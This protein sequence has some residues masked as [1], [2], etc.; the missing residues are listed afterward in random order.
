MT[1]CMVLTLV[2]CRIEYI[3]LTARNLG[4]RNSKAV[5]YAFKD[6]DVVCK[7]RVQIARE[8]DCA[9]TGIRGGAPTHRWE[10]EEP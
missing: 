8:D 4:R 3:Y 5:K 10:E 1:R 9:V 6:Y 2:C 7:K